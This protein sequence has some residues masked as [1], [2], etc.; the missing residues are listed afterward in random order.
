MNT[1]QQWQA[2][3]HRD[4]SKAGAFVYAVKTTKIFCRPGCAS[5]LPLRENVEFFS[6]A[7][8]ARDAG[9]RACKRCEPER[10]PQREAQLVTACRLLEGEARISTQ[11]LAKATGFSVA[12]FLRAFKAQFGVTPQQY[13]RRVVTERARALV[14]AGRRPDDAAADSGFGSASRFYEG[15]SSE[16]GMTMRAARRG[17]KNEVIS[18]ASAQCSLGVLLVGSTEHGVCWVSLGDDGRALRAEAGRAFSQARCIDVDAGPW[19]K[20]L[21]D[22]VEHPVPLEIPLA[23]RGT[24]FQ[25]RVWAYLR[26]LRVGQTQTYA[27]VAK[28]LGAPS[29]TRAVARACATNEIAIAVPCHRVVRS[30]GS[31]AGYRWGLERKAALLARE[32][33]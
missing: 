30:D 33:R 14:L 16:L 27:Q 31:L 21:V 32:K 24:A 10:R 25:Q 23:I 22:A 2:V 3:Q 29:S 6:H 20:A 18:F 19:V 28:A 15:L 7:S 4:A 8:A 11:A 13:R 9:F 5:R 1:A 12:H 26:T 17:A